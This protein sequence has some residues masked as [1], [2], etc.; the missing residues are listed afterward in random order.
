MANY[1]EKISFEQGSDNNNANAASISPIQDAEVVWSGVTNRPIENLRNRTEVLRRAVEDSKYYEDYDR[2]LLLRSEGLFQLTEPS[3]G[4]FVL[5]STQDIFV[6]PALTPGKQSGGRHLGG[7]V[8]FGNFPYLGSL[9]SELTFTASS[10]FTGQRGYYDGDSLSDPTAL[11]T[12]ANRISLELKADSSIATGAFTF[13]VTGEPNTQILITCGT[14]SGPPSLQAVINAVNND[15]TSQGSWGV[16]QMLRATTTAVNPSSV[17]VTLPGDGTV[18]GA[19][20]AEAHRVKQSQLVAFFGVTDNRLKDGEGLA[21]AFP[22]GPVQSNPGPGGYPAGGRRQSIF[23][24]PTDRAGATASNVTPASGYSLFNTGREPEKIPGAVPLG[25]LLVDGVAEFVFIDGT[26]IRLGDAPAPLGGSSPLRR[27]LVSV[28]PPG[29]ALVGYGGSAN[30]NPNATTAPTALPAGTVEAALDA[31]VTQ[32]GGYATGV[33]GARR[34]GFEAITGNASAGNTPL[35]LSGTAPSGDI[36]QSI[37]S[38]LNLLLNGPGAVGQ[39]YGVNYR[40]SERGHRM[41]GP[42]PL[43][44]R[45]SDPL[46]S[47]GGGQFVTAVLNAPPNLF[48]GTQTSEISH[49]CLSPVVFDD[50]AGA[51]IIENQPITIGPNPGQVLLTGVSGTSALYLKLALAVPA[52]SSVRLHA[53]AEIKNSGAADGLYFV[54]AIDPGASPPIVNLA[55]LA[56]VTAPISLTGSPTIT[57]YTGVIEGNSANG[58]RVRRTVPEMAFDAHEHVYGEGIIRKGFNVAEAWKFVE[59]ISGSIWNLGGAGRTIQTGGPVSLT[60]TSHPQYT[61]VAGLSGMVADSA[62]HVLTL[63]GATGSLAVVNGIWRILAVLSSSSVRVELTGVPSGT[64]AGMSWI[65]SIDDA[66]RTSNIMA[67]DDFRL[68]NGLQTG[69]PKNA[70]PTHHHGDM[71]TRIV[72]VPA[73]VAAPILDLSWSTGGQELTLLPLGANY[74]DTPQLVVT[75]LL[76]AGYVVSAFEV[77]V[78]I[79]V[80]L[81]SGTPNGTLWQFSINSSPGIAY[82]ANDNRVIWSGTGVRSSAPAGIETQTFVSHAVIPVTTAGQAYFG[83]TGTPTVVGGSSKIRLRPTAIRCTR[84]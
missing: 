1:D 52:V 25:K 71:Y 59:S 26:R 35:S 58:V 79:T 64:H 83:L 22:P 78:V 12:G 51:A 43:E 61:I 24:L 60:F 27:E 44:K 33:G 48:A 23:D 8:F 15:A 11:T 62:G 14:Q 55:T 65:E 2:A 47:T 80:D 57:F 66:A 4:E 50:G 77:D 42:A 63:L 67:V 81:A 7:R 73:H 10:A 72:K 69:V 45:F 54:S 9:G 82:D 46:T 13:A 49:A 38:A 18:Q 6:Y 30:W 37:Q 41:R 76:P 16:R 5:T 84:T 53:L 40:V 31:V 32:L 17:T 56:G 70:S 36:V 21:I 28:T 29:A 75:G 74:L 68:L 19:Y 20:D 3:S 34:V 39:G